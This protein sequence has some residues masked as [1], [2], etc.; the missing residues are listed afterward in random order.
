MRDTV[1]AFLHMPPHFAAKSMLSFKVVR[2]EFADHAPVP[3]V[4]ADTAASP[5][6]RRDSAAA[7]GGK[8]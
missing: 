6:G 5:A 4:P 8:P 1:W 2:I 7:R 3:A